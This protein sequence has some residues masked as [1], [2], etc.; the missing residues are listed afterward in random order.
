MQ[1]F[2]DLNEFNKRLL[3]A[4]VNFNLPGVFYESISSVAD[5]LPHQFR[6]L[7]KM[8]DS[9]TGRLLI[10]DEVGVGKTIEAGYILS[11]LL[12]RNEINYILIVCPK[13]L[14]RKW[15]NEMK[16]YFNEEFELVNDTKDLLMKFRK[17]STYPKLVVGL[18]LLRRKGIVEKLAQGLLEARD[19]SSEEFEPFDMVIFDEAHHLRNTETFSHKLAK[20]LLENCE[21]ALFLT[22]TPINTSLEDLMN[23]LNLLVYQGELTITEFD[24]MMEPNRFLIRIQVLLDS[25]PSNYIKDIK[26]Y[27]KVLSEGNE[28]SKLIHRQIIEEGSLT[29]YIEDEIYRT[30]ETRA[31]IRY[32]LE[33][34]NRLSSILNNTRKRDIADHE[35]LFPIRHLEVPLLVSFT[36]FEQEFYLRARAFFIELIIRRAEGT[37]V[38]IQLVEIM[39]QRVVA[40]SINGTFVK[41]RKMLKRHEDQLDQTE[42]LVEFEDMEYQEEDI[43]EEVN[44]FGFF[45]DN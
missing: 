19:N 23:L 43:I 45:N 6:P 27:L 20:I 14:D 3:L 30:A 9:D 1:D 22:A 28:Y 44:P 36:P 21:Y 5:F 35:S 24:E 26:N 13:N 42:I 7:M 12:A 8:L 18:E 40:S 2:I 31:K 32:T 38:P 25:Q 34:I 10:A 33:Q 41:L 15:I 4:K 29:R 11:E 39:P 17:R 37:Y 16:K